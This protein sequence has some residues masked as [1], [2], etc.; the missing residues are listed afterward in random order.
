MRR[1]RG[2]PLRTSL[3]YRLAALVSHVGASAAAG[4]YTADVRDVREGAS[5]TW[6]RHDDARVAAVAE[7]TV[8]GAAS[9]ESAYRHRLPPFVYLHEPKRE[10]APPPTAHAPL[11]RQNAH[12]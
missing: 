8:Y 6:R 2:A 5:N 4:H 11:Q 10:A 3:S 9:Q 12:G 7:A 1:R